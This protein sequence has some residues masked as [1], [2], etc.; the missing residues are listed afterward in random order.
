MP[1][2]SSS[3]AWTPAQIGTNIKMP[4]CPIWR[5]E[6]ARVVICAACSALTIMR[7]QNQ[8]LPE[9]ECDFLTLLHNATKLFCSVTDEILGEPNRQSWSP[10]LAEYLFSMPEKCKDALKIVSSED[11]HD[12]YYDDQ[13]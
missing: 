8:N 10:E 11:Y 7:S 5:Q 13:K 9:V 12:F 4:A 6:K 2:A 3:I 1:K